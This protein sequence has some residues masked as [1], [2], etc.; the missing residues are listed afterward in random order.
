MIYKK[1]ILKPSS[2]LITHLESDTILSY[3][4]AYNFEKLQS[5]FQK[6][7]DWKNIPF[8]ISNW[9]LENT[10]PRPIF[11]IDNKD[12]L[13]NS[14]LFEDIITEVDK[15]KIKKLIDIP[16]NKSILDLIFT[17]NDEK[18]RENLK[19]YVKSNEWKKIFDN[20]IELKNSIPRFN[21]WETIPYEIWDIKYISWNY[22]IYAKIENELDFNLFFNCFKNT[23]EKIWFWKWKSRWYWHFKSIETK[24]L[25]ENEKEV[26]EYIK[27][28]K[29]QNLYFV[30]N[31]F[32]PSFE[33]INSLN[34][35]KSFYEINM[36]HTKSLSEF[37]NNLIFKWQMNFF[38]EWSIIYSEKELKWDYYKSWNSY[39]FGYIF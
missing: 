33:E 2:W 18:L 4:F 36:K 21:N 10:L 35:D 26:L 6:F 23:F 28:L 31:N 7:K 38:K 27:E 16:F 11:F 34:L 3:I 39:S 25:E 29:K 19:I 14:T 13:K 12:K 24:D 20:V 37:N 9:F 17:W 15:K 1:I 32:K 8:I 30:L 5:I 22:E